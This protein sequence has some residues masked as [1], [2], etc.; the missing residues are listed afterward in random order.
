MC[1]AG[2]RRGP[3]ALPGS[4]GLA[5][6]AIESV[7][8][9]T[10][11]HL[12]RRVGRTLALS[13]IGVGAA[14]FVA[15][16]GVSI[17]L[18]ATIGQDAKSRGDA[19]MER[20]RAVA[21]KRPDGPA[22]R[23]V[24]AGALVLRGRVLDP[25]GKPVAVADI[26]S[27]VPMMGMQ[28]EARRLGTTGP[29]GRFEV[30]IPR[31]DF[32]PRAG[33]PESPFSPVVV[34]A[35]ANGLGPDW[36]EV[37]P[38]K[39]REPITLKLRRDD[40]PIEGRVISLEG[41]PIAGLSA[42]VDYIAEFPPDLIRRLRE[43]AGKRNPEVWGEMRDA[44]APEAKGAFRPVTTDGDG[45]FR[46]NG[47]GRDRVVLV[48]IEGGSIENSFAMVA[49][50]G[51]RGYKPILLPADGSGES[52]IERP[53]FSLTVAPG[54][55]IEGTV[56]DRATGKPIAGA[57]IFTWMSPEVVTDARG[58]F[59]VAGLPR[60]PGHSLEVFVE[61]EPY[62]KVVKHLGDEAVSQPTRLDLSLE[63]GS[64]VEGRIVR[65]S[66][67]GPVK[68][69]V[70]YLPFRDN[71][72]VKDCPDASFLD[73]NL[74]NEV[75]FP[76]NADGR[77]RAVA[78]PGGGI[79]AVTA[80]AP[81][82]LAA[83][84]LEPRT[85][86]NVL[87]VPGVDFSYYMDPYHALV[88]I[89][90]RERETLVI[91]EIRLKEAR[92]QHVRFV[93]P[94]GRPVAGPRVYCLQDTSLRGQRIDGD[95]LTFRIANPGKGETLMAVHEGRSLGATVELKGDE[96]DPVRVVLQPT[97]SVSGRLV[98]ED[99]QPRPGVPLAV[100]YHLVTRGRSVGSERFDPPSSGPDGRFRI[101][102]LV[103]GVTYTLAAIKPEERNYSL[104]A[105]GYL[106]TPHWTLKPGEVQEWGDVRVRAYRR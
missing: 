9:A 68:A 57:R 66:D 33:R 44:F 47:I 5:G 70:K 56:R 34:A 103:P 75:E 62:L 101:R 100:M 77:F 28:R 18:A 50:A 2:W 30:V 45:R 87:I 25:E 11:A 74:S 82:F 19:A 88:P 106:N 7:V 90:A 6:A 43:N 14:L 65:S 53:R 35:V 31:A 39:V 13:R 102:H 49:T 76:T 38:R 85:A 17:G 36:S 81:N 4:L 61:G 29:D 64:W 99:G 16:V 20:P 72:H 8:P 24:K 32:E 54:R 84:P 55:A 86:G 78:L 73:N 71:P 97:G 93:D 63:R 1:R 67:G 83:T 41:R 52:R 40:V 69:V 51:D 27:G 98:D 15:T 91:P 12:S 80:S 10:V 26:V 3:S 59:R 23:D 21:G 46:L 92:A 58:R 104:R 60:Q 89:E 37:D 95:V 79:L 94:E 48:V 22:D 42:R 105:E 96:P